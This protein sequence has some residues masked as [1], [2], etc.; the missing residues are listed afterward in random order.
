VARLGKDMPRRLT[1]DELSMTCVAWC[2]AMYMRSVATAVDR[3][4]KVW[5]RSAPSGEFDYSYG[6]RQTDGW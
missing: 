3:L 6:Y 2:G 1:R 4:V 5:M